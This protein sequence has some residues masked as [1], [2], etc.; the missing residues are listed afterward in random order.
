LT[1]EE[2]RA[3][4]RRLDT[5]K[6]GPIRAALKL[7]LL[8]GGQRGT[9][10]LR[11]QRADVDLQAGRVRLYDG[12]GRRKRPRVHELPLTEEAAAILRSMVQRAEAFG[13]NWVFTSNGTVPIVPDT[14]ATTV[15][16]IAEEMLKNH[17]TRFSFIPS[18]IRRTAET[19]LASKGISRDIRAQIQSHG[20]SGVQVRHYDRHD[21]RDEKRRVLE[22]LA[23]LLHGRNEAK[24]VPLHSQVA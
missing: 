17:E 10:L 14:L 13:C 11:L 18:D 1:E 8:L 19:L 20:L 15:S 12:K 5:L 9:Q 22:F 23:A 2:L 24:V 21:Y 6:S 16:K 4:W 3:Y 7:A